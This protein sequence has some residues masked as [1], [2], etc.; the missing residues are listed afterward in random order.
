MSGLE[1]EVASDAVRE[2]SGHGLAELQYIT[3]GFEPYSSAQRPDLVFWPGNGPNQSRA[4]VVEL[5]MP[6]NANQRLPSLEA[7]QEH[8]SFIETEP[9]DCLYFAFATGRKI[10]ESLRSALSIQGI[11]VFENIKSGLDL[12][13]RILRWSNTN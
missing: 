3:A 7:F 9:P 1:L 6:K 11:E 10:D 4:F 5:R 12:T 8:R 2:L 13:N